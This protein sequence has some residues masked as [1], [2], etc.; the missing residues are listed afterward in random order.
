MA[1]PR[2]APAGLEASESP[3]WS[4]LGDGVALSDGVSC[5]PTPRLAIQ[6]SEARRSAQVAQNR[7]GPTIALLLGVPERIK[8][9]IP[10]A[11]ALLAALTTLAGGLLVWRLSSRVESLLAERDLA[12]TAELGTTSEALIRAERL[13]HL[14]RARM[15]ST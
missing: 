3:S 7:L 1:A 5:N 12:S 10:I 15:A 13:F 4:L 2:A 6:G 9:T 8:Q 14:R 11:S